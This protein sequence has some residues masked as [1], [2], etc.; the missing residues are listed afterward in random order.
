M[1]EALAA[2][3]R[4]IVDLYASTV[5]EGQAQG[6]IQKKLD[7]AEAAAV[8]HDVWTGAYLR[9]SIQRS[10]EPLKAAISFLRSYL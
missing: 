9:A 5:S 7:P 10:A 1:R 6:S 3:Y 2:G 4:A 8:I